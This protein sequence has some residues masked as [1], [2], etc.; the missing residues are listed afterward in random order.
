M[1]KDFDVQAGEYRTRGSLE[2]TISK[3]GVLSLVMKY[4]PGTMPFEI[5]TEFR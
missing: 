2:G 3:E 4:R 1:K 5:V